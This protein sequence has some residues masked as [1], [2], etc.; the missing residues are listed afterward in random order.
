[1]SFSYHFFLWCDE[2]HEMIQWCLEWFCSG[3]VKV[4]WQIPR[5]SEKVESV[6]WHTPSIILHDSS[7]QNTLQLRVNLTTIQEPLLQFNNEVLHLWSWLFSNHWTVGLVHF[8]DFCKF[9]NSEGST[10][11]LLR[12]SYSCLGRLPTTPFILSLFHCQLSTS[13]PHLSPPSLLD[14]HT[15][16]AKWALLMGGGACKVT[17]ARANLSQTNQ[18]TWFTYHR[19]GASLTTHWTRQERIMRAVQKTGMQEII[20]YSQIRSFFPVQLRRISIK[21]SHMVLFLPVLW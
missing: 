10:W 18:H 14:T 21:N 6:H 5:N 15:S 3:W 16:A 9:N 11:H 4:L 7:S 13:L 19:A 20:T 17:L 1:M 12:S 8:T 2:L